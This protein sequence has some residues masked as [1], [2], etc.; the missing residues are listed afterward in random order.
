MVLVVDQFEELFAPEVAES[1]RRAFIDAL[2]AAAAPAGDRRPVVVVV[3]MRADFFGRAAE[4]LQL[5]P[6]LSTPLVVGPM[7][8]EQVREVIRRPAAE[9]GLV[10]EA[11]LVELL[12]RDL[13]LDRHADGAARLATGALPLLSHALLATWQRRE[14]RRL[15]AAGYLAS[16]GVQ[17]AVAATAEAA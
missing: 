8:G 13:H 16:G 14:G 10:P 7:T 17:N 3:G 11:G 2:T 6:A 1:D 5:Q 15:T 12:L 4:H 9:V